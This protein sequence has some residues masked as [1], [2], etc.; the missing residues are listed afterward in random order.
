LECDV[1]LG[2]LRQKAEQRVMAL[3]ARGRPDRAREI[4][5]LFKTHEA[6]NQD[7]LLYYSNLLTKMGELERAKAVVDQAVSNSDRL[8]ATLA[9]ETQYWQSLVP[10]EFWQIR[11][12]AAA[13]YLLN[14][15][16]FKS[17][18]DVGSGAGEQALQFAKR[19]KAVHCVDF[20]VSI[21]FQESTAKAELET[22]GNV[23]WT[24]GNFNEMAPTETYDLVWCSHILE[25][26]PDANRF[27]RHCLS[28]LSDYGWLAITVP[29]LKHRIVGGHVS[30]WNAGL[31]LYQ[32]VMA[33]ND[34]SQAIVMNYDYNIT[35]LV[36]KRPIELPPLDFDAG[37]IGRLKPYMPEGCDEGFDGRMYGFMFPE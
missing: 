19:D 8:T 5:E 17:V 18:L 33:G 32:I 1:S 28:Y 9:L 15:C 10:S 2:R 27:I 13:W 7:D 16:E 30:L 35:V 11:G 20:G 24:V 21:Y 4:V 37:D 6:S 3:M 25:H 29:P 23:R 22:L 36:R 26:Q 34:C 31:L 14:F 12:G